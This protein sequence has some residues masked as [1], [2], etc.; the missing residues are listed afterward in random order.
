MSNTII[1]AIPG[2]IWENHAYSLQ[3]FYICKMMLEYNFNVISV[4]FGTLNSNNSEINEFEKVYHTEHKYNISKINNPE[5]EKIKKYMS[6][7]TIKSKLY[8]EITNI[9]KK[10]KYQ[11]CFLVKNIINIEDLNENLKILQH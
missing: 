6:Y 10:K 11:F 8:D 2:S 4:S 7:E 3:G 9:T 1:V 5:I